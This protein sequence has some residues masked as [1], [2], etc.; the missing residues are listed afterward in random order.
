MV[1]IITLIVYQ[2]A[3]SDIIGMIILDLEVIDLDRVFKQLVLDFF[4]NDVFTI[5]EDENIACTE[6]CGIRPAL[7]GAIKRMRRRGNDF[8]AVDENMRQLGRFTD[9]LAQ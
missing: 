8:L 4:D 7:R 6:M 9:Y 5:D 3:G 2:H 1:I